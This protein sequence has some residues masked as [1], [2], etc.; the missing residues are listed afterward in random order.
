MLSLMARNG[1]LGA[2]ASHEDYTPDARPTL[3][4]LH[5]A[6]QE[7]INELVDVLVRMELP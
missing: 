1:Y 2:R 6:G 4:E 7:R 3:A 5:R